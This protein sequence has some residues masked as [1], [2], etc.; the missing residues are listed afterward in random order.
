MSD[1]SALSSQYPLDSRSADVAAMPNSY[2]PNVWQM[3]FVQDCNLHCA[4]CST[5][6]GRCGAEARVMPPD[7]WLPLADLI[8]RMSNGVP[9]IRIEFGT[10]ETFLHFESA[11]R[12]L[13][14]VRTL[15][16]ASEIEVDASMTT[17]GTICTDEHLQA[18]L[19]RGI[20]LC[21]SIDGPAEDHDFFRKCSDG[22]SSHRVALENWRRYR[23]MTAEARNGARCTISSVVAG[24]GRLMDVARF[25]RE[26]G[27]E[28]FRVVLVEPSRHLGSPASRATD[29][30]RAQYF[31]DLE[32]LAYA[33]ATRLQG[34]DPELEFRGPLDILGAWRRLKAAHPYCSCNAGYSTIAAGADGTLYPCQGFAGFPEFGIGDVFSGV[35]PGK[36]EAFRLER[37]R[38]ER[39]CAGCW[40][41]FLCGGGCCAGAP[42]S[43][44]VLDKPGGCEFSRAHAE[45]AVG[46][47]QC[48]R[49]GAAPGGA[50][51]K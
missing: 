3:A 28:R 47:F 29:V 35:R 18:C 22:G 44:M 51:S 34:R 15:A 30:W 23:E 45:I 41:R 42:K 37:T 8:V 6:F 2:R 20:L 24:R 39:A 21:F 43:G 36:I 19:E 12:F 1:S 25:W 14:H 5:G 49:D 48:W 38:L 33:E 40:A 4:Y 32:T 50:A 26:Q 16:A 10:G 27:V 7:I 13:D 17:N 9:K 31:H 46:S 11:I